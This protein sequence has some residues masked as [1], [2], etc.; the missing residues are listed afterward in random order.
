[1]PSSRTHRR[2][3]KKVRGGSLFGAPLSYS[4]TPG[5]TVNVYGHF[6]TEIASSPTAVHDLDVYYRSALTQGCGTEDSSR[7]VP[8]TMGSNEVRAQTGGVLDLD[9][10]RPFLAGTPPNMVQS[11]SASWS[12][13]T[14]PVPIP[15]SPVHQAWGYQSQIMPDSIN[16]RTFITSLP[17]SPLLA[18]WR[19]GRRY[20]KRS[21]KTKSAHSKRRK[22]RRYRR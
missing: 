19:G 6:P 17:P 1:M 4:M 11:V 14:E 10:P 15:A 7:Q 12:G 5:S 13:A 16:P 8:A 21:R 3:T 9:I 22:T 2:R 20:R 18:S